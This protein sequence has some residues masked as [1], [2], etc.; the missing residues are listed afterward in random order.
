MAAGDVLLKEQDGTP[1][2]IVFR[3]STD[4]SPAAAN[5]LRKGSPTLVQFDMTSLGNGSYRQSD[6]VDLGALRASA[7]AVRAALEFSA[8]PTAGNT[9]EFWW[10][11]SPSATAGTANAGGVSG[12]D[13]AYTGYSSNA[14]A[15]VQQLDRIG[16]FVCTAQATGTVQVGE[17]IGYLIPK[18][19]Y[20]SLVEKNGGGSAMHSDAVECHVVLD[21]IVE[22]GQSA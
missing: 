8:T 14:D 12:A 3:D 1:K 11:P 9:V 4:F 13:G 5:D 2:Q 15:S 6:K 21:P 10:A 22:Q 17:V 19:R 7:Y 18:E 20:G 16:V